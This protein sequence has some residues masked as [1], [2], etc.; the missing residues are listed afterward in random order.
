MRCDIFA[1]KMDKSDR[2][3][4]IIVHSGSHRTAQASPIHII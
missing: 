3:N 2:V 4:G 1:Y